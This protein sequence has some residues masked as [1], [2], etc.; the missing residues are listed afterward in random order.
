MPY[1]FSAGLANRSRQAL[2]WLQRGSWTILDQAFFAGANFTVNILLARW[3]SVAGYGTFAV[4]YSIFLLM[5][6]I[7][8]GFLSEPMLVFSERFRDR[9]GQYFSFLN[10]G[11]LSLSSIL[12]VILGVIGLAFIG[13]GHGV[14][15]RELII[16][17]VALPIILWMWMV[18]RACY[19][20]MR[21]HVATI[22]S[23]LYACFVI[24]GITLVSMAGILSVGVAFGVISIASF[25]S[26]WWIARKIGLLL[27]ENPSEEFYAEARSAHISYGKWAAPTGSIQWTSGQFALMVIPLWGGLAMSGEFKA[28]DNLLMPA[29]HVS[30]ALS[31]LLLPVFS[32]AVVNGDL[33]Q[34]ATISIAAVVALMIGFWGALVLWGPLVI[35]WLYGSQYDGLSQ[36]LL[37]AGLLPVVAAIGTVLGAVSRALNHPRD[38]FRANVAGVV[39]AC[40]GGLFLISKWAITGA[41]LYHLGALFIEASVLMLFILRRSVSFPKEPVPAT[42]TLT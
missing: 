18:R 10:R 38:V 2:P 23:L 40:T 12:S 30:M 8:T 20:V 21:P 41:L 27:W 37:L 5:G 36:Y 4:G 39:F 3:L 15:G 17:A 28:L 29:A 42:E 14:L 25:F 13:I 24:A 1:L 34:K 22:G 35:S 33:K 7:H 32:K 31:Y 9:A 11:H 26:G 19:A 6:T 16:L